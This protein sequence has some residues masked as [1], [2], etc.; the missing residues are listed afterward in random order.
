M[1]ETIARTTP[2]PAP[3]NGHV[4]NWAKRLP[5]S[6]EPSKKAA[7]LAAAAQAAA[8]V[9]TFD[10]DPNVVAYRIERMRARVDRLIWIGLIMGLAFTASNVQA[11]AARGAEPWS[12]PWLSGWLLDPI[13]SLVLVGV[14]L[15]EQILARH[16]IK[17]GRW[18]RRT[19]WT[20]LALTYAMNTWEA[21][22]ELDPALILLHS[23]P[24]IVVFCAAEAAT[25]LKQQITTAVRMA[26]TAALAWW[27]DVEVPEQLPD[28]VPEPEM[29]EEGVRAVAVI[30]DFMARRALALPA[31]AARRVDDPGEGPGTDGDAVRGNA[32]EPLALPRSVPRGAPGDASGADGGVQDEGQPGGQPQPRR[33]P[34]RSVYQRAEKH[35]IAFV[36]D[37]ARDGVEI[38][39]QDIR[40]K[41][42]ARSRNWC[43]HK[44]AK[45]RAAWVEEL[46]SR[47]VA[48]SV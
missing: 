17:A 44:L 8:D 32:A 4:N 20:T 16:Q 34:S 27:A 7:K 14:L 10:T 1:T 23:V 28:F 13:V 5:Q 42:P 18:V 39:W 3:Q 24:P 9:R 33:R 43:E 41:N 35:A 36:V 6:A 22:F 46:A 12:I 45:G 21:W 31:N 48:E 38:R 26:Y 30:R 25:T 2:A 15:G 37:R 19:K 40:E 29:P 11:F 47:E